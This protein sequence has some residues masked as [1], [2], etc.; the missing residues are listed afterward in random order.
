MLTPRRRKSSSFRSKTWID[1]LFPVNNVGSTAGAE[2]EDGKYAAQVP[3]G[4]M[5]V[6]IRVNKVVGRKSLYDAPD[7][8]VQDLLAEVLPPKYNDETELRLN[9]QPGVNKQ[10]YNLKTVYI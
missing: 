7:S 8:P 4:E 2:I 1:F 9:V 6:E 10:D 3:F 5:M